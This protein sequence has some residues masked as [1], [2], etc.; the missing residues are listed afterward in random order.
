MDLITVDRGACVKCGTCINEC[1]ILVLSMGDAGPEAVAPQDCI[2]CGHC[3]AV[4]PRAALDHRKAPLA[5]QTKLSDSFKLSAEEA[6]R[7]LR[8]PRSHRSYLK[9][10]VPRED[11]LRLVNMARFAHTGH[12][13]QGVSY[14]IA[15]DRETL[16]KAVEIVVERL[17]SNEVLRQKFARPFKAYHETGVDI[18]LRGAPSLV[19]ATTNA[20]FGRGRENTIFSLTYLGLYAPA[21]GLG[22]CWAGL[23]ETCALSDKSPLLKLFHIPEDQKI[24]GAVMVGYPQYDYKRLVDRNPLNVTF[25]EREE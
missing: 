16:D 22:T 14:V 7:F 24:T 9:K 15:D 18:I 17:E 23:F 19:L 5:R 3:V 2:A 20:D 10:A 13:T 21:L 6:E 8:S 11:L 4:C 1:P 25:Y 12:N